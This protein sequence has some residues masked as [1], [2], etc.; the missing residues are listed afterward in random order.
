M[1]QLSVEI[2]VFSVC[3]FSINF[4]KLK[5][6]LANHVPLLGVLKPGVVSVYQTD[7]N[8]KRYFGKINSLSKKEEEEM[9]ISVSSGSVAVHPDS[10]VQLLAEEA[11]SIENLDTK[12]K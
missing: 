1:F 3:L 4:T 10:T 11:T 12:V 2:W 7:G 5:S 8:T 9:F 6:I